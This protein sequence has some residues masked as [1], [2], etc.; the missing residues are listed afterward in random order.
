MNTETTYGKGPDLVIICENVVFR[1]NREIIC[2]ASPVFFA[3]LKGYFFESSLNEIILHDNPETLKLALDL[4]YSPLIGDDTFDKVLLWNDKILELIGKYD[5]NGVRMLISKFKLTEREKERI[6]AQLLQ[7][8][9][10]KESQRVQLLQMERQLSESELEKESQREQFLLVEGARLEL[11]R[12]LSESE[13]EKGR[14]RDQILLVESAGARMAS[15]FSARSKSSTRCLPFC[16]NCRKVARLIHHCD[17]CTGRKCAD[18]LMVPSS[19]I[20]NERYLCIHCRQPPRL[21]RHCDNCTHDGF[22]NIKKL[23]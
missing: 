16:F 1:V 14:Q 2:E 21:P 6:H 8:K 10:E 23:R 7:V 15:E 18:I 9:G 22:G 19:F 20:E 12:Q 13:L 4:I 17:N 11:R 5:M 3:M